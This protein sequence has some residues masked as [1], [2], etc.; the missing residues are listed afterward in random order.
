MLYA[1]FDSISHASEGTEKCLKAHACHDCFVNIFSDCASPCWLPFTLRVPFCVVIGIIRRVLRDY[2]QPIFLTQSIGCGPHFKIAFFTG[3]ELLAVEIGYRIEHKMVMKAMRIQ[4]R[5]YDYLILRPQLRSK[6]Y[7]YRVRRVCIHFSLGKALVAVESEDTIR[8][9]ELLLCKLHLFSGAAGIAIKRGHIV[10][11]F[12]LKIAHGVVHNVAHGL[13]FRLAPFV[14]S[15]FCTV[16][17]V[18]DHMAQG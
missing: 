11:L 2:G 14:V 9:A 1:C 16:R 17:S 15:R 4:V 10:L 7:A 18:F 6:L 8:F 5:C 12:G 13:V 3:V